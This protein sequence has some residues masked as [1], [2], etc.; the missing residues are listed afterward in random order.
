MN[1]IQIEKLINQWHT[2]L[3]KAHGN[4]T[5][6]LTDSANNLKQIVRQRPLR[7]LAESPLLCA[8]LCALHRVQGD[9]L[10]TIERI[11]LYRD[12]VEML[13][14]RRDI[15]RKVKADYNHLTL[16]Y[17]EKLNLIRQFA[18]WMMSNKESI[19]GISEA[20]SFFN[21][22]LSTTTREDFSSTEARR[23]FVERTNLLREP[24]VGFIEFTHLTFEEFLAAQA[25]YARKDMG[26][27][28]NYHISHPEWRETIILFSGYVGT[29]SESDRTRFLKRLINKGRQYKGK[30]YR[31]KAFSLAVAC[32]E[33]KAG[34][35]KT[36]Q[37]YVLRYTASIFPPK[38]EEEAKT[39]STAGDPAIPLLKANPKHS[40]KEAATCVR[41]LAF[42]GSPAA[43]EAL[44][45]FTSDERRTVQLEIGRAWDSFDRQIYI[46]RILSKCQTLYLQDNPNLDSFDQLTHLKNLSINSSNQVSDLSVLS[47]LTN[48]SKLDIRGT[49][50]SD[51]SPLEN[52]SQLTTLLMGEERS[53]SSSRYSYRSSRTPIIDLNPLSGCLKIQILS[54]TLP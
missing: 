49:S 42:I 52:L 9:A 1:G 32:L 13:L 41:A 12:C 40:E 11:R 51:L 25:I 24:S 33:G 10:S 19:V 16:D 30:R 47:S 35:E 54:K 37:D 39:V 17:N 21:D 5:N 50:V 14:E 22:Y 20:D 29:V 38:D 15:T 4:S 46:Q 2:A 36:A 26:R 27:L 3:A 43:L 7:Q 53:T 45:D 6:S 23:Y 48:L 31:H 28:V 34:L 8:M 44:I 18:Y